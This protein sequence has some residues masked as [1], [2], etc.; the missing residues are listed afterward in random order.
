MK[1]TRRQFVGIAVSLALTQ[2]GSAPAQSA[3]ATAGELLL[4]PEVRPARGPLRVHPANPRYFADA[5]GRAVYLT[6]AHTW[7]NLV[8]QGLTD[9]PKPFGFDTYLASLNRFGHNFIRLW[10]WESTVCDIDEG[11]RRIRYYHIDSAES[12]QA[13]WQPLQSFATISTHRVLYHSVM[14]TSALRI[15][16]LRL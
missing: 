13:P 12:L 4:P 15:Y 16:R 8:D 10:T 9:P 3:S 11:G 1:T 5:T 2:L 6:G 14:V 7:P